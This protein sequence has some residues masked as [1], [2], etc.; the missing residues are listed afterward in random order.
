[1]SG[2]PHEGWRWDVK[3]REWILLDDG[4]DIELSARIQ[5]DHAA[6]R[7]ASSRRRRLAGLEAPMT[8]LQRVVRESNASAGVAVRPLSPPPWLE[9]R[10]ALWEFLTLSRWD[11][12]TKRE[13]GTL[14]IFA[15]ATGLKVM[16]N[17]KDVPRVAF[18]VLN[19]EEDVWE[20]LD[21]MLLSTQ[22]DWRDSKKGGGQRK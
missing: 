4:H 14:L 1:M 3:K 16:L 21:R 20:Q 13:P 17:D 7:T 6:F 18:A 11:A 9:G 2:P 15:D 10:D 5:A 12:T 22:T 8:I 19:A